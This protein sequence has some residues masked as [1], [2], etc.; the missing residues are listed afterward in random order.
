MCTPVFLAMS[1]SFLYAD[2]I[3]SDT[4]SILDFYYVSTQILGINFCIKQN[5]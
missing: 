1:N 4:S 3:G 5:K 2:H